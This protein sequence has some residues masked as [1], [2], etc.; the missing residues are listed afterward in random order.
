MSVD[1]WICRFEG[2]ELIV[3]SLRAT[4]KGSQRAALELVG[5]T[6]WR[7]AKRRGI[8]CRKVKIVNAEE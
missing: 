2:G 3:C 1:F 5:A 6:N 8:R 7:E 4:K